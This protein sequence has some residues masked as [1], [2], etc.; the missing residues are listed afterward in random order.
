MDQ[1]FKTSPQKSIYSLS[2]TLGHG[3]TIT[4]HKTVDTILI[5]DQILVNVCVNRWADYHSWPLTHY[6]K[7]RHMARNILSNGPDNGLLPDGTKPL[8][9]PIL[10][11]DYWHPYRKSEDTTAKISLRFNFQKMHLLGDNELMSVFILLWWWLV[12]RWRKPDFP[13][14]N[15]SWA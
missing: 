11:R 5:F 15:P 9:K 4:P 8:P 10:T 6:P 7:W 12:H 13:R 1:Q 3:F 2:A 14:V